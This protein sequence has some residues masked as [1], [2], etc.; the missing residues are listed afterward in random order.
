[1]YPS[2]LYVII[3]T[4]AF[5]AVVSVLLFRLR[6]LNT[7]VKREKSFTELFEQQGEAWFIFDGETLFAK[8]ANQKA[9]NMFGIF[10]KNKIHFNTIEEDVHELRRE[11]RWLSIYP[12]AFRGMM[13]LKPSPETTESQKKYLTHE[14]VTSPYNLMP[15]GSKLQHHIL[16]NVNNFYALSWLIA[17]LGKL[18]DDGLRIIIFNETLEHLFGIKKKKAEELTLAIAGNMQMSIP[19]ILENAANIATTFFTENNLENLVD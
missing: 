13:Q 9:L 3:A 6:K 12:Q 7:K 18:K 15:D 8:E 2:L 16:L 19:E 11:L 10:K 4:T 17:E 5:I 1:M 14:I